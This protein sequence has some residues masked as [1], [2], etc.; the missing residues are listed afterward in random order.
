MPSFDIVSEINMQEV[1]NAVN[2]ARKEIANRYDFRGSKAKIDWDKK[3]ITIWAE[4]DYKIE[5]MK[6]ILQGRLHHRG[7]DI[8]ALKIGKAEPAGHLQLKQTIEFIQGV[9]KEKAKKINNYI[10]DTKL[11]VQPQIVDE[12]IRVNSKSIDTLRECMDL[13]KTQSFGLPIQFN[14]FK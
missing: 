13:L 12:K 9:D 4:D 8:L 7:I 3:L 1:D 6:T 5:T 11:K 2:Q 10:R 14:N